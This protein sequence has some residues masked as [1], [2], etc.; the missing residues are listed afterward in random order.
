MVAAGTFI[1]GAGKL[2]A[3]DAEAGYTKRQ[4]FFRL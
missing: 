4:Y 3:V 1:S 2:R